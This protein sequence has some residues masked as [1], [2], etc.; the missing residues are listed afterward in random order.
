M[1]MSTSSEL[2]RDLQ[3]NSPALMNISRQFVPRS[4]S[5]KIYAFY[6]LRKIGTVLVGTH[7]ETYCW[8]C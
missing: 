1:G 4:E 7:F 6:E 3:K 8:S 2:S 5:L